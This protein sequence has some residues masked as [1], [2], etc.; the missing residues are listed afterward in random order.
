MRWCRATRTADPRPTGG[1]DI[2]VTATVTPQQ[3]PI[4]SVDLVYVVGYGAEVAL[5]MAGGWRGGGW[6]LD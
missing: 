2:P 4:D 5:P 6:H 1:A 3:F